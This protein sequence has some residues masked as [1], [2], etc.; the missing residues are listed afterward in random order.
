[1]LEFR[2][3]LEVFALLRAGAL[4]KG[5]TSNWRFENGLLLRLAFRPPNLTVEHVSQRQ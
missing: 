4:T 5:A 1:V 2:A 3:R